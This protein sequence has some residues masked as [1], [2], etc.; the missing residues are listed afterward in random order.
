MTGQR[1]LIIFAPLPLLF[2]YSSWLCLPEEGAAEAVFVLPC[3]AATS[4]LLSR[5]PSC[6][7]TR[8][9]RSSRVTTFT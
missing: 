5:Q 2:L 6:S 7:G 3:S 8:P 1:D 4:R 9:A